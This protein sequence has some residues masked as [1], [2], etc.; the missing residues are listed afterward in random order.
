M[1]ASER[2]QKTQKNNDLI[3]NQ[4]QNDIFKHPLSGLGEFLI[5]E[6]KLWERAGS[7][8][9]LWDFLT[10]ILRYTYNLHFAQA[11]VVIS[12]TSSKKFEWFLDKQR[13]E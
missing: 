11:T 10:L 2:H 7:C 9:I 5:I 13:I 4:F 12:R 6:G 3:L 1:A 8:A